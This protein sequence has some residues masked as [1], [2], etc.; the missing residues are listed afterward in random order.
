VR[1]IWSPDNA[2]VYYRMNGDLWAAAAAG[3]ISELVQHSVLAAALSPGNTLAF[4][5]TDSTGKEPLSLSTAS[6]ARSTPAL[7]TFTPLSTGNYGDSHLAYSRDGSKLGLWLG[8]WGGHSELWVMPASGGE[9]KKV[10]SLP[11]LAHE[12]EW[13]PDNRTI[14]F[15]SIGSRHT[16]PDL[17]VADT[18]TGRVR[19]L[20]VTPS[21]LVEPAVS[22]DGN[23]LAFA[24]ANDNFDLIQ[25][26][27]DGSP[28]TNLLSTYR[29][30]RDASWSPV[31]DQYVYTTDRTGTAQIW[32][33]SRSGDWERPVVT[34]KDFGQTWIMSINETVFSWDGQRIAYAVG[35]DNGHSVWISS[36]QGG[37]PQRLASGTTD[38]RSP[39]WGP[40]GTWIAF[41]E[42]TGGHWTPKRRSRADRKSRWCC[43]RASC[44]TTPS[45]R[46]M[47]IGSRLCLTMDS[48]SSHWMAAIPKWS[49]TNRGCCT[50]GISPAPN[51]TA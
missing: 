18:V 28:V 27:L 6:P 29:N 11:N 50:A 37:S 5:R 26:P 15:G 24:A 10:L 32:L 16:R 35:G 48:R 1:P 20:T 3:G 19:R 41:L 34:E 47:E 49:A 46:D 30:E 44:P 38:Q 8:S 22:P 23:Q 42:N 36:L 39:S 43:D 21:D 12:F 14:V 4:L 25:V 40:D 33:R 9:P 2:T 31:A 7:R 17:E 45:G 51:F 13:L